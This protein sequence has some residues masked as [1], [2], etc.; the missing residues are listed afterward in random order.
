MRSLGERRRRVLRRTGNHREV[1]KESNQRRR[2]TKRWREGDDRV[3]YQLLG[4]D[5]KYHEA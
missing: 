5:I 4:F 1:N 3:R 2:E